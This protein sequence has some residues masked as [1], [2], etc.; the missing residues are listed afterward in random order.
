MT[1]ENTRIHIFCRLFSV[2]DL[3]LDDLAGILPTRWRVSLNLRL[4]KRMLEEW[5]ANSLRECRLEGRSQN[6]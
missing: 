5:V 3:L 1:D 2:L 6:I 4:L